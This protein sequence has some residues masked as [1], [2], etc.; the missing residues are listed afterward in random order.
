VAIC[1]QLPQP[2]QT[3]R[4]GVR[5]LVT[6]GSVERP[7]AANVSEQSS[8]EKQPSSLQPE[9]KDEQSHGLKR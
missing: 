2:K 7:S 6:P 8:E 1:D 5:E 9:N 3:A 4:A